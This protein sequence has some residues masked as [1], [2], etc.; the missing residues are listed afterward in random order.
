MK[1][2]DKNK[3]HNKNNNS[4]SKKV[5]NNKPASSNVKVNIIIKNKQTV[6]INKS[7]PIALPTECAQ[8][9][10]ATNAVVNNYERQFNCKHNKINDSFSNTSNL[11]N[12]KTKLCKTPDEFQHCSQDFILC[13]HEHKNA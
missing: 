11:N 13:E 6:S 12:K 4:S 10:H 2:S 1:A 5:S 8:V 7:L 9:A 3:T